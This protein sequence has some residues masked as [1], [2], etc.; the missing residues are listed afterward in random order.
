[1][2]SDI[3]S[4]ILLTNY[5]EPIVPTTN[6]LLNFSHTIIVYNPDIDVASKKLFSF[7]Y[8]SAIINKITWTTL[9]LFFTFGLI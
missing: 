1:L 4:N 2:T 3:N 6:M 8:S 9:G 7:T 5:V